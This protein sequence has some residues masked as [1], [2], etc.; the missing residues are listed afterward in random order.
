MQVLETGFLR[1]GATRSGI[2]GAAVV[3]TEKMATKG[4]R[5]RTAASD[6]PEGKR[7][8]RERKGK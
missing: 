5:L 4:R 1:G 6:T 7:R 3:T 2:L 8:E